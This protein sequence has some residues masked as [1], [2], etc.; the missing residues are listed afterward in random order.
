MKQKWMASTQEELATTDM[1]AT[2]P[3]LDRIRHDCIDAQLPNDAAIRDMSPEAN[4]PTV[5]LT[6]EDELV[7]NLSALSG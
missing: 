4:H 6:Q 5:P 1:F 7:Q 2:F 3:I